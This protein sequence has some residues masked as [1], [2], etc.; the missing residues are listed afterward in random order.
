MRPQGK[1]FVLE[2]PDGVGK[3]TLAQQLV[4]D[5]NELGKSCHYLAFPGRKTGSLGLHVYQVHHNPQLFG[6][7]RLHPTSQQLLHVAAHIDAIETT[8]KPLL[9]EGH[10]IILDR[11]WWSMWVYGKEGG[12]TEAV[13]KA[14][15]ACEQ[16]FWDNIHPSAVFLIT[17]SH[18]LRANERSAQWQRIARYYEELAHQQQRK[19]SVILVSNESA[20]PDTVATLTKHIKEHSTQDTRRNKL[21][22]G[23][24]DN[25][26]TELSFEKE[27]HPKSKIS[28]PFAFSSLA[29]AKPTEVFD[30]YWH[31]AVERQ[32][33]FFRRLKGE[34][35]PWTEDAIFLQYKFTNAY[36][37]SDRVSQYLIKNVIYKGDQSPEEI[38]FRIILFKIFNKIETWKLLERTF[39]IISYAEYSFEL[40]DKILSN[41]IEQGITIFSAAYIMPSHSGSLNYPRKHRN[42]LKL[43]EMMI[44]DSVPQRI[45]EMKSM[46]EAFELLRSYPLIGDFLAYQY[47]TDI[48]YSTI[49]NFS[50]ME[51]VIPGPGAR[52]GIRKCFSSLGG[53]NESDI[54]RLTAERQADEFERL[55]LQFPSLWGRSLQLIDC[56]NLFCEV[57]KYARIA[58]PHVKGISDRKRIKQSYQGTPTK[59][60]YWYPPKWNI[61]HLI[62]TS[63][64]VL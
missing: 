47:I 32:N 37:A 52:D 4:D 41:T 19:Y 36:R 15:L 9:E 42:Y 39:G 63:S 12:I 49:V 38:F 24:S 21:M 62:D 23:A 5:L 48:N 35:S 55:H 26:Q 1:L 28:M 54:I 17:R 45:T 57:D 3:S 64:E 20:I 46:H 11:W 14:M 6:I 40:Y 18:S 50:E 58:H 22:K 56:Q 8:I 60:H 44:H 10:W 59:I 33:I 25:L 51:F 13:L 7:D 27:D 16:L 31:F 30:T 61:N 2:G 29:P 34:P 53:L 43:I